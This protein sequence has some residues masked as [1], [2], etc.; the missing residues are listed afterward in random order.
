MAKSTFSVTPELQS[1]CDDIYSQ[2]EAARKNFSSHTRA[3]SILLKI[4]KDEQLYKVKGQT[5]K[6]FCEC[7]GH[8]TRR[9]SDQLISNLSL[10]ESITGS[11]IGPFGP[12]KIGPNGPKSGSAVPLL[13]LSESAKKALVRVPERLREKTIEEASKSGELTFRSIN[14]AAQKVKDEDPVR[15]DCTNFIIPPELVELFDRRDEIVEMRKAVSQIRSALRRAQ[16]A[17]DRLYR[18]MSMSMVISELDAVYTSLGNSIP[19]ALC[20]YCQGV[21]RDHCKACRGRGFISEH[22]YKHVCDPELIV[23]RDKV[24]AQRI[25]KEEAR[26]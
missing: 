10:P 12:T 7:E 13:E 1:R 22:F 2:L 9:W 20:P 4:V 5:W 11:H 26:P 3:Y 6:E 18:D 23:I 16:E 24:I 14:V 21:T 25:E 17:D 19:F 8:L 15:V